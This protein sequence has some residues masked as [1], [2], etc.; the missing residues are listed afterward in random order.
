MTAASGAATRPGRKTFGGSLDDEIWGVAT[1]EDGDIFSPGFEKLTAQTM[2]WR[3]DREGASRWSTDWGGG[4]WGRW[5][6][7]VEVISTIVAK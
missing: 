3:L 2:V 1:A 7:W 6:G 4:L 5:R